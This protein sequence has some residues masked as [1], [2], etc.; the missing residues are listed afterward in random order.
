MA[1][2]RGGNASEETEL[3]QRIMNRDG[4]ALAELYDRYS[5]L[6]YS[7]IVSIV[8][9]Q[10]EAEDVLQECFQQ[11]WEKA[12]MFDAR[13]GS[14]YTWLV[15]MARNRAIDRIRSK[16]YR[17]RQEESRGSDTWVEALADPGGDSPLDIIVAEE[18]SL[19][20]KRALEQLPAD[21]R[22]VIHIAYFNGLSQSEIAE[23][24][25]LPLGTVKTRMR[26]GMIKL[27]ALLKERV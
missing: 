2:I 10:E 3:L 25:D 16:S 21:Q 6:L 18:R 15:T 26:Q 7:L 11:A 1:F 27:Y 20:V 5:T 9:V 12:P 17:M 24:L 4:Q 23:K 14:V 22:D 8:K 19:V 13:K